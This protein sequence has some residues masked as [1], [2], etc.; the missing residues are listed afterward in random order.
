VGGREGGKR[1]IETKR[2]TVRERER[3]RDRQKE[4]ERQ[5]EKNRER[6]RETETLAAESFFSADTSSTVFSLMLENFENRGSS[7]FGC[8]YGPEFRVLG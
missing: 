5:E 4:R 1:E 8:I 7:F 6:E 2:E 3:E